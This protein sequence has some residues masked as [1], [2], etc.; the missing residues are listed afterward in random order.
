[1][2]EKI[3]ARE[4]AKAGLKTDRKGPQRKAKAPPGAVATKPSLSRTNKINFKI[5][6]PSADVVLSGTNLDDPGLDAAFLVF[7][8]EGDKDS[9]VV[10]SMP[11]WVVIITPD[12]EGVLSDE[13]PISVKVV[14]APAGDYY[15][16]VG[17]YVTK[18]GPPPVR[19]FVPEAVLTAP[20]I[21]FYVTSP[22]GEA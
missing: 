16:A 6:G 3:M 1:L 11:G 4:Q 17:K 7:V 12:R 22:K 18:P 8:K 21:E 20:A 10:P 13:F 14:G 19:V 5:G 9:Y 2:Q 15:F